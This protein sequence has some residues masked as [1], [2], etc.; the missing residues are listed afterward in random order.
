SRKNLA[1]RSL[2][3]R[4]DANL[5][6]QVSERINR[7]VV[8]AHLVVQVRP[9]RAT[10]RADAPQWFA[11]RDLLPDG[12]LDLR[13]VAVARRQAVAVIDLDEL[14]IAVLPTGESD[15]AVGCGDH[16][17]AR[18]GRDVLPGVKL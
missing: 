16:G 8:N 9:R 17:R 13:Q 18:R 14:P 7:R 11:A 5:R 1:T 12:R 6:R 2:A 4:L 3:L 15:R 10:G